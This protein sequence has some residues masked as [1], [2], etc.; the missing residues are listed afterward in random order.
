MVEIILV[1]KVI[2]QQAVMV[3]QAA[4]DLVQILEHPIHVVLVLVDQLLNQV[5]LVL[6]EFLFLE[7]LEEREFTFLDKEF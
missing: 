3:V 2:Q 5:Y 6:Q 4:V 7:T 1:D